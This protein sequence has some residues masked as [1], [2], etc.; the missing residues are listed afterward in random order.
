MS[1]ERDT[2]NYYGII[3]G[4]IIKTTPFKIVLIILDVVWTDDII[5]GNFCRVMLN[6]VLTITAKVHTNTTLEI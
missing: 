4:E 3:R 6:W 1:L 5:F 2:K